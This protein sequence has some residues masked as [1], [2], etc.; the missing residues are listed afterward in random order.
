MPVLRSIR[1]TNPGLQAQLFEARARIEEE[2]RKL[3][4]LAEAEAVRRYG[5]AGGVSLP[6]RNVVVAAPLIEPP[7]MEFPTRQI[8]VDVG[9][10]PPS[11]TASYPT[12]NVSAS[13]PSAVQAT[14]DLPTYSGPSVDLTPAPQN[15]GGALPTRPRVVGTPAPQTA[16]EVLPTRSPRA[17]VADSS[18]TINE[19]DPFLP[20]RPKRA[21]PAGTVEYQE[22]LL[23]D[24]ETLPPEKMSRKGGAL[25]GFL[26]GLQRG[27]LIGGGIG[28][29]TGALSPGRIAEAK[30]Q[31][32]IAK[33]SGKLDTAIDRE[34]RRTQVT[35]RRN[36]PQEQERDNL[37][38]IYN[39][40]PYFDP[41][42]NP[43]HRRIRDRAAALGMTLPSRAEKTDSEIKYNSKHEAVLVPKNGGRARP[44]FNLDGSPL[45]KEA[46]ERGNVQIAYRLALDGISQIQIERDAASGR[47]VD[48]VGRNGQP[49]VRDQVSRI[50]PISGAPVSSLIS[51]NRITQQ[52]RQENERKRHSYESETAEWIGKEK[53]FRANKEIEDRAIELKEDKLAA[54]Y[55]EK[56]AGYFGG[57]RSAEAIKI[58]IARVQK[59]LETHRA[60]AARFQA[61]A[62]KAAG[63]ATEARRNAGLYADSGGRQSQG[64]GTIGRAPARDGKHHYSRAE[65]KAEADA[66]GKNFDALYNIL[67]ANKNVVIDE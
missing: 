24:R 52:Q 23:R 41:E 3:R 21:F 51:D 58:D 59:D 62:D 53:T 27:G 5:D 61:D 12:R 45:T 64:A 9:E 31:G 67:K 11:A 43:E 36:A 29:L 47:W 30:R 15:V 18:S 8:N 2:R 55:A 19:S 42:K 17:P 34:G 28:A 22:Q 56:P 39:T 35:A 57:G 20:T 33:A 6:G 10:P 13:S 48:S 25:Y 66:H 44:I 1:D 16:P 60:N 65:I 46:N 4:E 38:Q 50:D 32:E 49:I 26:Q 7:P 40:L 37:R 14:F 54:L 63:S